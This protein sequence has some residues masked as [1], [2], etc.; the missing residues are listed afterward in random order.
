LGFGPTQLVVGQTRHRPV[1][2]IPI[3]CL[4]CFF[5]IKK[6]SPLHSDRTATCGF[7]KAGSMHHISFS[8]AVLKIPL[9]GLPASL[10]FYPK[11]LVS[12]RSL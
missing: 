1:L 2:E 4:V 3:P 7:K 10:R 8:P 11:D 12:A 6:K 5:F 9:A